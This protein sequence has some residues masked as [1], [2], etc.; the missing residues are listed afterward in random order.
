LAPPA[1]A[2][3]P[4]LAQARLQAL[5]S[6][7]RPHFLFNSLN[8]V[9]GLI[10]TDPRRAETVIEDLADLF[11]VLMRDS[12]ERVPLREEVALCKQY[13]AIESLRLGPRL[14]VVLAR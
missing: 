12:R 4:A 14:Q 10:R 3:S 8:A 2:A 5:Q 13:L 1:L 9:L 7:I 6:R 11:R